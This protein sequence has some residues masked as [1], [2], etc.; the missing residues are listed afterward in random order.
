MTSNQ[1]IQCIVN[2][3]ALEL[4]SGSTVAQLIDQMQLLGKRFAVEH[5]GDIVSKS[6]LQDVILQDSDRLEIVHAIGGG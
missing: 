6:R 3:E 5:N 4:P 1:S 2:G